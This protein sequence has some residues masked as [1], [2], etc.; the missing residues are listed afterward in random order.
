MHVY[1]HHGWL[2]GREATD[3]HAQYALVARVI[4]TTVPLS[5]GGNL[6]ADRT[7]VLL[8]HTKDF[9]L[10]ASNQ[11]Q[12]R[13]SG[14]RAHY[15]GATTVNTGAGTVFAF[16]HEDYDTDTYHDTVTNNSRLVVG[17][18]LGG[19]Y[20]VTGRVRWAA[21][22]NAG[23]RSL[24]IEKNSAG[25]PT[26]ANVAGIVTVAAS[27]VSVVFDV[28]VTCTVALADGDYVEL[29]GATSENTTCP[30]TA[31]LYHSPSFEMFRIGT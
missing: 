13:F 26:V 12:K 3:A 9:S 27:T 23:W 24:R 28:E 16:D 30:N 14:V 10:D 25:T 1:P 18:G 4:A 22:A 29:I 7:L 20:R 11:L 5:G 21:T 31:F 6:S 19:Y 15:S 8:Y 17:A 2:T